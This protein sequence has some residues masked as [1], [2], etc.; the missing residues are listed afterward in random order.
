MKRLGI[1]IAASAVALALAA[2]SSIAIISPTEQPPSDASLTGVFGGI[3]GPQFSHFAD[4]LDPATPTPT[5]VVATTPQPT[6][7]PTPAPTEAPT[8]APSPFPPPANTAPPRAPVVTNPPP[9]PAA[10][11]PPAP[12]PDGGYRSDMS[13]TIFNL[14]NQARANNGVAPVA[15]NSVLT[16]AGD[17]YSRLAF[18]SDPYKLNHNLDGGPGDRAWARGYCCAVGE[19]LV[20]SEGSPQSMVDLWMNSPAHHNIIVDPQYHELGVS[21]YGGDYT[22][23]DGSVSHPVLCVGEFGSGGG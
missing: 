8:P 15:A 12:V 2:F 16:A 9:A 6:P 22:N 17:Y 19:I 13:N 18:N 11:P 3:P 21:C 20:T 10:A 23:V 14:L 1:G 5:I 7:V 4:R